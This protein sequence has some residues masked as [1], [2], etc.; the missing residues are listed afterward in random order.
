VHY[1]DE[2]KGPPL[3]L[4]S[5]NPSWSFGYRNV[6]NRL[7]DRFRCIAPDY[8][9]F[10]LSTASDGYDFK[11][12]S[13]SRV[14]EAL[15]GQLALDG[16]TVMGYDWGGPIGLGVAGRRPELFRAIVIGNTFAWPAESS[17]LRFFSALMG[18][19]WAAFSSGA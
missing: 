15:L 3:L 16:I 8:P 12:A 6:I 13:H 1:V 18:V 4:L 19:P 17:T 5:G 10:G 11:P 2:G 7:S 14:I 9:G